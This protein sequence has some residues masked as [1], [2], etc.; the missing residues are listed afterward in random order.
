MGF[1]PWPSDISAQGFLTAQEFAHAHGDIVSIMFIGGL[2]WPETLASKPFSQD[3]ENNLKYRPPTGK[4]LFLS[5]SPLDKDR[6]GLAP[7]WGAKDNLPLPAPWNTLPFNSPLVKKA[8]LAFTLRAVQTMKPD[9]LAIGIESNVLLSKSPVAWSQMKE[10]HR[11]TYAVV[12]KKYPKL[13]VFFTTEVLH[14]K[15]LASEAKVKE[16]QKEVADLMRYSDLFAM[17]VYPYMS[18]DVPRPLPED[19]LD[20]AKQFKKP[21]AVSESGMTSR[22]VELRAFKLTLHGSAAD[23]QHFTKFCS[24]RPLATATS[25]SSTSPRRTLKRW[26]LNCRRRLTIS[27]VSGLYVGCN[28]DQKPSSTCSVECLLTGRTYEKSVRLKE[29][30]EQ[31][32]TPVCSSA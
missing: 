15:G 10:L 1:T 13:P 23:Q 16:Q 22:D 29:L 25:S 3:V 9:Y 8:F 31:Q 6:K 2:P 19:F 4:K 11:E 32:L 18:F 7:Y 17:S 27:H 26:L 28:S 12:K 21:L 5:I 20:F 30:A 14:Y 24:R